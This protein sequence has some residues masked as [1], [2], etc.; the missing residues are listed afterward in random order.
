MKDEREF[1]QMPLLPLLQKRTMLSSTGPMEA[2]F[3][4]TSVG[5]AMIPPSKESPLVQMIK[6][7]KGAIATFNT[8]QDHFVV[9]STQ[10]RLQEMFEASQG[11]TVRGIMMN[12]EE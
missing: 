7:L 11:A 2:V 4:A 9:Q 5:M 1:L 12:T 3:M 8:I 10:E 6:V